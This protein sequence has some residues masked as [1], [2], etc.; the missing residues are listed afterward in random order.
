MCEKIVGYSEALN[1]IKKHQ[2]MPPVQT[3]PIANELGVNV[4]KVTNWNDNISGKVAKDSERGGTSGYAIFVNSMHSET[5]RRFT[6][7]HEIAHFLLH[8]EIIGDGIIDDAL[9][10]SGLSNRFEVEANKFAADILMPL[11]LLNEEIS[12]GFSSVQE[13]AGRFNVSPSAM[14]IRISIPY[15]NRDEYEQE[16]EE[17]SNT[18]DFQVYAE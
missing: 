6:I 9:Y 5:R 16:M 12:K 13:L 10:R 18:Q 14:S 4:Y 15:E 1:L 2:I 17:S 11:H 3:V 7:A 8:R